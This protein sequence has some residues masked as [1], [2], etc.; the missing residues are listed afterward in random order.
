MPRELRKS[1]GEPQRVTDAVL[2]ERISTLSH[3]FRTP[4]AAMRSGLGL[5]M[6]GDAGPVSEDQR[7]FLGLSVRH[8]DRLERL[9][10]DL[11]DSACRDAERTAPRR[12]SVDLGV[13]LADVVGLLGAQA[14]KAGLALDT[15]GIPD[16]YV[17]TVDPDQVVRMVVNVLGNALKYGRR[18]GWVKLAVAPATLTGDPFGPRRDFEIVVADDGPGIDPARLDSVC[19]PYRRAGSGDGA[20]PEGSG[21]GLYI[22]R[23]L[24]EEHGGILLIESE[25]ERGTTV[26]IR[27][28]QG[29][30]PPAGGDSV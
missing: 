3:E 12:R 16:R 5:V 1:R 8:I 2:V 25:P 4:L 9:V 29:G 27:L 17:V 21:L 18:G 11:L 14:R 7:R 30:T 6:A 22:T 15:A 26:R 20:G 23:R 13:L 19:D 24:V 10:G 28:P